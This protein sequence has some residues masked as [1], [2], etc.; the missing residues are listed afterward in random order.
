M[1][2]NCCFWTNIHNSRRHSEIDQNY[3]QTFNA[4][5]NNAYQ[6]YEIYLTSSTRMFEAFF[7]NEQLPDIPHSSLLRILRRCLFF[8]STT[9]PFGLCPTGTRAQYR[10]RLGTCTCTILFFLWYNI[11]FCSFMLLHRCYFHYSY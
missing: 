7:S 11:Y 6:E 1:E 2:R 9:R 4:I 5:L 3:Q 10:T 8:V